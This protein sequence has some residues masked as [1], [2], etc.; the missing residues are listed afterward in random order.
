MEKAEQLH[1]KDK[2]TNDIKVSPTLNIKLNST[3]EKILNLI[4]REKYITQAELS[5]LLCISENCIYKNL[6]TLKEKGIHVEKT[7]R[8]ER[9]FCRYSIC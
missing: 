3:A 4:V 1:S 5:K 7:T 2:K 8:M 9:R 6:K